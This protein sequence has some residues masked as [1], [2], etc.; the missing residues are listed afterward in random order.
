MAYEQKP[1]SGTLFKNDR[2]EKDSHPDYKGSALIGGV[3]YWISAWEKQGQRGVFFSLSFQDKKDKAPKPVITATEIRQGSDL[4][5][6][7]PF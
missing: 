6:E 1:N 7:I 5:D 2:K 3:E 4:D